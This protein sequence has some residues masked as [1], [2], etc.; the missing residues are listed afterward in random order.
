MSTVIDSLSIE[1]QSNS[2]GAA[3]GIDAL[4]VSLGKLK[5]SGSISV[6]VKNLNNLTTALKGMTT[7]ASNANKISALADSMEKLKSVGSI[8]TGVKKLSESLQSLKNIDH[9][10]LTKAAD[11]G[12]LFHRIAASLGSL[13]SVKPGGFGTMVN[14]LGKIGSV[15]DSLDDDTIARFTDRVKKLSESLTPL[16]SKMTSVSAGLKSINGSA[17]SAGSGFQEL[18]SKVTASTFN[19]SNAINVINGVVSALMPLVRLLASVIGDAME[20]DGIKYQFGNSFGEQADEYYKKI[21]EITDALRIN[22]QTFMENSAMAS[23]M[24]IGFGVG[25]SDAR[26]MGVG[27]TELAYDIWAAFNNVYKTFDGADG[28]M[29]AVRSAIAG[30]VEPIRRAGFT[31]VDSQLAITAANHGIEY[32][33]Q[34]ASEEMKS[35]LRYLTLVD[36]AHDKGIVGAFAHEMSTAEGLMRTFTQQMKSLAQAVGSLFLPAIVN[37]MPYIQALVEVLIQAVQWLGALFGVEIQTATW[38]SGVSAGTAALSTMGNAAKNTTKTMGDAAEAV[39]ETTDAVKDLKRATI[40]IDELNVISPP[41]SGGGGGGGGGVGGGADFEVSPLWDESIYEN[42]KSKVDEIKAKIEELLPV[43]ATVAGALSGLGIATLLKNLGEAFEKMTLLQKLF[44]TVATVAIEA[45][46]VFTF[47]DNYLE[48]G[49]LLYLIGEAL[50]TAASGYLLFKAWGATG[51]VLALGVSIA[52]QLVALEMS[53]ADGTVSLDS[54][55]TWTQGIVAIL[56]GAFGGAIVSKY[57]GFFAK[58]GFLIGLAATA[59]LTL[60][61]I[62]L[63]A[64]ESGEISSDSAEAWLLEIG[65]VLAAGVGGRVLGTALVGAAGG[66]PGLLI[67][68]TAGLVINLTATIGSKGEDFGTEISDWI[69]VA[70]TAGMALFTTGKL[71][72]VISPYVTPALAGLIPKIGTALSTALTTGWTAITGAIAAIPVWGWIAA[73]VAGLLGIA[74][75]DYDFTD[76]GKKVGEFIGKAFRWLLDTNEKIDQWMEDLGTAIKNGVAAAWEWVSETFE[77]DSVWEFLD[78][79][80]NPQ[81]WL[82]KLLPKLIEIGIEVIPGIWEGIKQGWNNFWENVGEFVDGFVQGFKDGFGISSPATT[83][84]PIGEFL[85]EGIWEGISGAFD[86]ILENIGQWCKDL[87]AGFKSFF[88]GGSKKTESVDVDVKLVKSGWTTVSGWIGKIPGVSQAVALI[89]S[90]WSSVSKWIGSIPAVSQ[91]V[92]LVKKGWTSVSKWIGTMPTLSAGIKLVKSGWT[93]VKS[94]LGNLNFNLG[95]KLPKIGINWGTKEVLGFKITYPSGFY[96]YAK[97]GFPDMGELFV[98]REAGPEMV[99]KIGSKTTVANNQ[100][101]VEGISEGVY[102]AV[103]A[104][105]KASEGSGSQSVNV[106]LDGRQ[107]TSSVEKRQR[108]RGASIM[109]REV[110][111]Y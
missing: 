99:G 37:I 72:S 62:R 40:G 105:M 54:T 95:F 46:L 51:A 68:L 24:L 76:L 52:A 39:D 81:K 97:G 11:A 18:D 88:I 84:I 26:E 23:S 15:T 31:I 66:T 55:E 47:A 35:Y 69:N 43:I 21:T 50:V 2:N 29:A 44:A 42:V 59:S 3:Q 33:A 12:A 30:E 22:K 87:W 41:S 104:A 38:S 64:I 89:K 71:W 86:G 107:I 56:T 110:Y 91:G 28:A 34:S 102:A 19:L 57:T 13:S 20:W 27:Y 75:A 111:A 108:E 48:S 1:I 14:A 96:T 45:I 77:I 63:G 103:L 74:I 70:L 25:E 32:S 73:A 5:S 7:V 82:E 53:L 100:Q 109:G 106:Y 67:G 85:V 58:E 79:M 49:N 6:A 16:S 9:T 60:A 93:S 61:A 8:G 80:F 17:K 90:G 98:A 92:G 78:L 36:Q 101:I 4:A 10:A 83:M 94:W 65:S